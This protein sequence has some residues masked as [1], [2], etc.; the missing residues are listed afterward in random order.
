MGPPTPPSITSPIIRIPH[1]HGT[2]VTVGEPVVTQHNHQRPLF[3]SESALGV[4]YSVGLDTCTMMACIHQYT[5]YF[6]CPKILCVPSIC[7]SL[8]S[9]LLAATHL[10]TVSIIWPFPEYHMVGITQ[11]IAF[12]DWFEGREKIIFYPLSSSSWTEN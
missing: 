8:S 3:T 12:S 2:F 1:Q 6:H 4:L 10:V 7:S 5:V 11:C 9:Q